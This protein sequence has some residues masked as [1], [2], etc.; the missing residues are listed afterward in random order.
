MLIPY[1]DIR[2]YNPLLGPPDDVAV[3]PERNDSAVGG[4]YVLPMLVVNQGN[5]QKHRAPT[6]DHKHL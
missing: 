4:P 6:A 3:L 5:G 1:A 2:G